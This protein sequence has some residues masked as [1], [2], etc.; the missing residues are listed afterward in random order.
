MPTDT[1]NQKAIS[2]NFVAKRVIGWQIQK[3]GGSFGVK[4]HRIWAILTFFFFK[5]RCNF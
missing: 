2:D 3:G 1:S 5:F 4:L